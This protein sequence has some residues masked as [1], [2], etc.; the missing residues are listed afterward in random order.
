MGR[1]GLTRKHPHP[2]VSINRRKEATPPQPPD[3]VEEVAHQPPPKAIILREKT[4]IER[5]RELQGDWSKC[6]PTESSL[7]V[8]VIC[9]NYKTE[10]LTREALQTFRRF[11]PKVKIVLV[12]NHSQDKSTA[13]IKRLGQHDLIT[14]MIMDR[15]VGHGPAMNKAIIDHVQTPYAFLLDSDTKTI[16]GGFLEIMLK[17]LEQP[18]HYAI[19]WL[20][21]VNTDG[22]SSTTKHKKYTPYVHPYAALIKVGLYLELP[23]FEYHGAPCLA[24]MTKAKRIGYKVFDF[25]IQSYIEHLI[26]GTRRMWKGA[27]DV[28]GKPPTKVWD[29]KD[30]HPI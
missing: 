20:R 29:R 17:R 7:P 15:N 28:K 24:N 27:W 21:H 13:L 23:P 5:Q 18:L 1:R 16:K 19:G 26:A 30:S 10:W 14:P 2:A 4:N 11:Y 6:V 8:T 12:D 9:V 3:K 22:V 25:S